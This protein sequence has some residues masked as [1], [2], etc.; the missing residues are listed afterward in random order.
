MHRLVLVLALGAPAL[1]CSTAPLEGESEMSLVGGEVA[2]AD[3]FPSSL[4]IID[5]C[6]GTKA[7]SHHILTAAHCLRDGLG[8]IRPS[9]ARG[10]PLRVRLRADGARGSEVTTLRIAQTSIHPRLEALCPHQPCGNTAAFDRRDALDIAVI[11]VES[12]LEGIPTAQVDVAPPQ[13]GDAITMVG[14]GCQTDL[15][16]DDRDGKLRFGHATPVGS[17]ITIHRDGLRPDEGAARAKLEGDFFFTRGPAA[18]PSAPGEL[19]PGV[20][21]G[22]SGGAV[23]RKG[24]NV[25]VGVNA[26]YTRIGQSGITVS[27]WHARVD[28][29]ARWGAA[30][31][32]EAKGIALTRSCAAA[33]C[34]PIRSES[35]PPS[36]T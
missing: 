22:D 1:A 30:A 21:S 36:G 11:E 6:S 20:C 24:T 33:G 13:I 25:V 5:V 19:R 2:A 14:Y 10:E 23:Y 28:G 8:A 15:W 35:W 3:A 12:G 17:E 18:E 32:L 31:W 34:A 4:E 26:S 29:E 9:F 27:N 7:G 16:T